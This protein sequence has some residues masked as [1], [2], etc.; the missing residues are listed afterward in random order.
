[1]KIVLAPDSFK[2]S[3][4]AAEAALCMERGIGRVVPPDWSLKRIPMADG[5]EGT[6][7]CLVEATGGRY[8]KARVHDPLG[9]LIE[10]EF[11]ILGDGRTAVV[12][13]A[14][15]SGL[16]LLRAEERNP[17]IASTFGYGELIRAALDEGARRFVL[18]LGGSAT[19]DGGA[20]MLQALG[21]A[22]LDGMGHPLPP[23]GAA[24]SGLAR[25]DSSNADPRLRSCEWTVAC[26]VNHP[27]TGPDGASAV[28]GP[29]KGATPEM[30]ERL[31]RSLA[32]L[33]DVMAEE[34]GVSVHALAG[35]GAAGGTAGAL[36]AMLGATLESGVGLCIRTSGL[37]RELLEADLVLTGEGRIDE[38]TVRGK[39][40]FGVVQAAWRRQVPSILIGG[41]VG[42]GIDELYRYGAAAVFAL[43]E[44]GMDTA[45]AIARAPELLERRTAES[46]RML[47]NGEIQL[48]GRRREWR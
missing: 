37:E 11:G 7:A 48:E 22:L 47:L 1:M 10:A 2:G 24:L 13:L 9:R 15:S 6:L 39:T 32:R 8:R 4:T 31:D 12:E 41:F 35:A 34:T 23:G 17:L 5:G 28:F 19:N 16:P 26:D 40:P 14:A 38:Q 45:T 25:I 29:Q 27:L 18:C 33:A 20:G 3:L 42:T 36:Y 44:Q 46:I 30:V 43:Q 21:F